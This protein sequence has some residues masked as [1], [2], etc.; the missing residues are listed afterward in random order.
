LGKEFKNEF[1]WS[2]S[3]HGTFEKCRRLFFESKYGT[4]NGWKP[5][6][7]EP[8]R[9]AY[10]LK[11]LQGFYAWKGDLIHRGIKHHLLTLKRGKEMS[12]EE[13][14]GWVKSTAKREWMG[15]LNRCESKYPES[16]K[17]VVLTEHYYPDLR[18]KFSA[19][20][21]MNN[22]IK[23][24]IIWAENYYDSQ[25]VKAIRKVGA[26]GI[27]TLEDLV[28]IEIHKTKIW[29]KL[30]L[31]IKTEKNPCLIIDWKSGKRKE[32]D[33]RQLSI[34]SIYAADQ[35]N[36][37]INMIRSVDVYLKEGC[38]V[39]DHHKPTEE[40]SLADTHQFIRNS[41]EDMKDN[42]VG[43]DQEANVPLPVE[44]W[45][46]CDQDPTSFTCRNCNFRAKCYR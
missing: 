22:V 38:D 13:L 1:T 20:S 36:M 24:V 21:V 32:A 4:W 45:P 17:N 33:S 2:F 30:D 37:P 46:M 25:M 34:Y 6:A 5:E 18:E 12:K 7:P 43:R 28:S 40:A 29:V 41:I 26:A 31:A 11:S 39:Y 9:F 3:G 16:K 44:N 15:S 14:V 8:A 23:D 19:E 10:S 42:L 27:L 35:W